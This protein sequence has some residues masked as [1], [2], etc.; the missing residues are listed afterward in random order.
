MRNEWEEIVKWRWHGERSRGFKEPNF[1]QGTE[2]YILPRAQSVG[3]ETKLRDCRRSAHLRLNGHVRV[4]TD[5][6]PGT[7]FVL[8]TREI[9]N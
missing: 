8:G 9:Q 7:C 2:S 4:V 5:F 3:H 1:V 6:L